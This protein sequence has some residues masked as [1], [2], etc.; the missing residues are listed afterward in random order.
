LWLGGLLGHLRRRLSSLSRLLGQ[1][2]RGLS[3]LVRLL[4]HLRR[5]LGLI[6]RLLGQL[7]RRLGWLLVF[8]S[9]IGA[10]RWLSL[11]RG[12]G[13]F[14]LRLGLLW[15]RLHVAASGGAHV[16]CRIVR[17]QLGNRP[18]VEHEQV[19]SAKAQ[20]RHEPSART[21]GSTRRRRFM[22][23]QVGIQKFCHDSFA[24]SNNVRLNCNWMS[25]W[26]A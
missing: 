6:G 4:G 7:R 17:D 12:G 16:C 5:T 13:P 18:K 3:S 19:S 20:E 22:L 24:S 23:G 10:R 9:R 26:L 25:S 8:R 21:L 11:P 2:R 14:R 1:L 15:C